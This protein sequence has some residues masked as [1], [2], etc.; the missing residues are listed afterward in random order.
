MVS[1][2]LID[3]DPGMIDLVSA[4]LTSAGFLVLPANGGLAGL[5][6]LHTYTFDLVITE[7][8]MPEADGLEVITNIKMKTVQP[9][10]VVMFK[11]PS[12]FLD[13]KPL[14]D[15]ARLLGSHRILL[16][17]FTADELLFCLRDLV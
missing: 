7:F 13:G 2:L 8:L 10:I 14:P 3:D 6:L 17:P 4:P 11:A 5:K 12:F 1:V 16:K 9:K 15:L